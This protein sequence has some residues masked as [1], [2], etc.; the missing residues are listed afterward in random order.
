MCARDIA[1]F[2]SQP[3]SLPTFA[4]SSARASTLIALPLTQTAK[5]ISIAMLS[6]DFIDLQWFVSR[7]CHRIQPIRRAT[8]QHHGRQTVA[9][10]R[11][12]TFELRQHGA[13][14]EIG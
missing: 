13:E 3:S 6:P 4:A 10:A 1:I 7:N 5:A 12:I 14:N 9:I 2:S 8:G 11:R